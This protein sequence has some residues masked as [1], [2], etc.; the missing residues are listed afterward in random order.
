ML[1]LT[2][3]C[4]RRLRLSCRLPSIRPASLVVANAWDIRL[5]KNKKWGNDMSKKKRKKQRNSNKFPNPMVWMED[6]GIHLLVP[7]Q[8]PSPAELE[9]IS[10]RFQHEIRQSSIWKEMVK[11]FGREKAEELLTQCRAKTE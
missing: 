11:K 5:W 10:L 2:C 8:E 9:L 6:D 4:N 1:F 3:A 7:G